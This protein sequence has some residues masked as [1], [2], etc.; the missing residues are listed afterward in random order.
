MKCSQCGNANFSEVNLP[1]SEGGWV[2]GVI[3]Y[4]CLNCGHIELFLPE[5]RIKAIKSSI[6][7]QA[8]IEE[9]NKD[10][11]MKKE[12]L[13]KEKDELLFLVEDENQT[14]KRVKN[15]KKRLEE[16]EKALK[17]QPKTKK[18]FLGW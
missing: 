3:S 11:T 4:A 9:Y 1:L 17:E 12:Q 8:E 5:R 6:S 14:V 13:L 16:I 7:E 15:A 2:D 18:D 10:L